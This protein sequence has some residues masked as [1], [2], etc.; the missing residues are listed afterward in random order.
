MKKKWIVVLGSV[1]LLA[2]GL[3]VGINAADRGRY[4]RCY[5]LPSVLEADAY[6]AGSA[7]EGADLTRLLEEARDYDGG[8]NL[9]R[10]KLNGVSKEVSLT[11]LLT[12]PRATGAYPVPV[13]LL[14][15]TDGEPPV[16][17]RPEGLEIAPSLAEAKTLFCLR[18]TTPMRFGDHYSSKY[19][20]YALTLDGAYRVKL[21]EEN[22]WYDDSASAVAGLLDLNGVRFSPEAENPVERYFSRYEQLFALDLRQV[23]DRSL[24]AGPEVAARYT[25]DKEAGGR[26]WSGAVFERSEENGDASYQSGAFDLNGEE[27]FRFVTY[28]VAGYRSLG[29]YTDYTNA[30]SVYTYDYQVRVYDAE[31]RVYTE[32]LAYFNEPVPERMHASFL[33]GNGKRVYDGTSHTVYE[34]D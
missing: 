1:V 9:V 25:L 31:R 16:F 5:D 27:P 7:L 24:P 14:V 18:R 8:S 30:G 22:V 29:V 17:C 28:K 34:T 4:R 10:G 19:T 21:A 15:Q 32:L 12:E 20:A 3:A 26:A 11:R 13:A 2:A 33:D 23:M 6:L